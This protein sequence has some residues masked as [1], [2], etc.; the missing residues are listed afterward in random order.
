MNCCYN[1]QRRHVGCHGQC[2]DYAAY[3]AE[4]D[5][6]KAKIGKVR[7]VERMIRCYTIDSAMR[8]MKRKGLMT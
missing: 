6:H 3:K 8:G 4:L 7:G 1:C 2:A 5:A